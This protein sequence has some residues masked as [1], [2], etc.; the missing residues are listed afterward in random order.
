MDK[1][2]KSISY[3]K[4]GYIFIAP[5][6]IVFVLCQLIPLGNTIYNSFFESYTTMSFQEINE[7]VGLQNYI[8]LF[9][10]KNGSIEMFTLTGNTMIMWF[11]GAVPQ[12]IFSL[13]LAVIFTSA[14]LNIK[15]QTFFKTVM[16]MPNVIMAS[17]FALLFVV[18]LSPVGPVNQILFA[19]TNTTFDFLKDATATRCV[20]AFI[21]FLMW[22]GNTTILL[23]AGI[24]GI[25]QSLFEAASIDGAN[26]GQVFFK[27]TLPLL[28]PIMLYVAI[29][30]LI[31]GLQMFDV[32]QILVSESGGSLGAART[33]IM[34]LNTVINGSSKDFGTGGAISVVIFIIT[35]ILSIIVFKL[36]V[37]PS[38]GKKKKSKKVKGAVK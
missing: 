33:L 5:F 14:R 4:W 2:R 18:L 20:V 19:M 6:F 8:D 23:M 27:I 29:T 7:F 21:N 37:Q 15:G 36:M 25:D 1:K 28:M 31:G 17:A 11:M 13:L 38:D 26:S 10:P 32:P 24:M 9:T 3:A 34:K 35:G 22:F 16:Y 12:F 30:S